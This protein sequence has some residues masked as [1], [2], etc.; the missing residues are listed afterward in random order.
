MR[1]VGHARIHGVSDADIVHALRHAIAHDPTRHDDR[2]MYFGP[3]R[4]GNLLQVLVA[5]DEDGEE[6]VIH[7][8]P[9]TDR[10][11]RFLP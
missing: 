10:Y 3:D 8:M 7:A 9:I 6:V 1:I 5:I 4:A 11:L 2:T